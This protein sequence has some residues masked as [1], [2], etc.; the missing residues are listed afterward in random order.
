MMKEHK[1]TGRQYNSKTCFVCG[2]DNDFG[3]KAIFYDTED[4]DVVAVFSTQNEHQSYP[5]RLHGGVISAILDETMGRAICIGQGKD[6]NWGVTVELNVSFKKPVPLGCELKVVG[7]LTQQN[8]RIFHASGQLLL[9]DGQVAATASGVYMKFAIETIAVDNSEFMDK[10]WGLTP[11][12]QI[13]P[14][15]EY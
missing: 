6:A 15:I 7:R 12:Q 11:E 14:I 8:R 13:P 9:P 3:L 10:E 5:G 1:I 2:L 4:G